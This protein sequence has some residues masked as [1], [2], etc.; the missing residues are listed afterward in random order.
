MNERPHNR[1]G[2]GVSGPLGQAWFSNRTTRQ[3]I[4][5]ALA[6]GI[7]HFDTGP[8]YFDAE[9]RLGAALKGEGASDVFIST[10]TG[11]RRQ[12]GRLVKD[13]SDSAIRNDVENSMNRLGR[14][15]L[16]LLYLHG[17]TINEIDRAKPV[18]EALRRE[19]KVAAIGV[20]GE[21]EPLAHAARSGFNAIMCPYNIFDRRHETAFAEAKRQGL[22]TVAVAPLAQGLV[23]PKFNRVSSLADFWRIARARFRG[24]YGP[25]QIEAARQA[26]GASEPVAAALGFVLSN[27]NIDVVITTTTK[28]AHL[29]ESLQAK[30][31]DALALASLNAIP[32][33]P[34][35]GAP[36]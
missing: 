20:C 29:A 5:H 22:L 21:G 23:D 28:K 11:T 7:V 14:E 1:L 8:F 34:S 9:H 32:L 35:G 3:L 2:F 13:F 16:D 36:S 27:A 26:L 31:L 25:E 33:T 15:R 4:A 17:P 10:K 24:K 6:G 18:L 12:G 30:P 19:G